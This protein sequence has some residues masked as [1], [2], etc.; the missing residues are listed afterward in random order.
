MTSH[1]TVPRSRISD[2]VD[3][4]AI[5][6]G[7]IAPGWI[8]GQF[9][10][11]LHQH[12]RSRVAAVASSSRER[13][14]VFAVEHEVPRWY[15]SYEQLAADPGID[16]IYVASPHSHHHQQGL[17]ALAAGKP[18]LM[19][20]ALTQNAGQA[21]EVIEAAQQGGLLLMEAMWARF[22]P[23]FDVVRQLLADGSLGDVQTVISDHGQYFHE[24][25]PTHRLLDPDLAGGALLDLG[26]YPISFTSFVLGAPDDV[27]AVA[28][29]SE[30]GVDAQVS[31]VLRTGGAHGLV[32]ATQTAKTPTSATICGTLARVEIPDQFYAPQLVKLIS[33]DGDEATAQ[34]GPIP[35]HEGLAYEAA[36]FA[37]LLAEGATESPLLPLA[38]SLSVMETMDEIRR[39][40]GLVYP[41]EQG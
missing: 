11:A 32:S 28:T 5:R 41:N 12:T 17:L 20:K 15:D 18:V 4:P 39:Q 1:F 7:V 22:L 34:T 14:E 25:P 24:L 27:V 23:H 16:A 36:H 19:E 31:A 10:N 13:A 33:R 9:T 6:W 35:G 21:K 37:N 26:V 38:E 8:A 29:M 40:I 30:T 2:P 3:A